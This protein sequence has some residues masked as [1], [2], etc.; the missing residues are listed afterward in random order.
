MG[1]YI[2]RPRYRAVTGHNEH[3]QS[4]AHFESTPAVSERC[5]KE[6][7]KKRVTRL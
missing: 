1:E 7:R 4:G 5:K 6:K 2:H 3:S